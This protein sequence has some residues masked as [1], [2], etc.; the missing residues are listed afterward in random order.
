M[1]AA[2]QIRPIEHT[3][4]RGAPKARMPWSTSVIDAGTR[5]RPEEKGI[6]LQLNSIENG[7]L[8]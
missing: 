1:I 2:P 7:L 5:W 6:K 4:C 3:P 8:A